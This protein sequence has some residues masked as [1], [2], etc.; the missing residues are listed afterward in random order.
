MCMKTQPPTTLIKSISFGCIW[1]LHSLEL[2]TTLQIEKGRRK[3]KGKNTYGVMVEWCLYL[4]FIEVSRDHLSS[5]STTCRTVPQKKKRSKR[6]NQASPQ[7]CNPMG[8]SISVKP[9]NCTL[10]REMHTFGLINA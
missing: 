10:I 2:L 1:L 3:I 6:L 8:T 4:G 9:L 5:L 7:A